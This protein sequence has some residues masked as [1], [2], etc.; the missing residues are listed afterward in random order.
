MSAAMLRVLGD[1]AHARELARRGHARAAQFS[2]DR[3]ARETLA[4]YEK[5]L[6]A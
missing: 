4:V 6:Q 5:V 2:W 1:P 3:C